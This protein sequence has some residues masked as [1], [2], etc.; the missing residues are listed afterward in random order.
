MAINNIATIKVGSS[1][2]K[3]NTVVAEVLEVEFIK[4]Q[5]GAI[6]DI[7]VAHGDTLLYLIEIT[8]NGSKP[9]HS[10]KFS[11]IVQPNATYIVGSFKV[12]G[13]TLVPAI[14]GS[15]LETTIALIA[16]G[17]TATVEFNVIVN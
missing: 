9:L 17:A 7:I 1:T 10:V 13:L 16:V 6:I 2:V 5:N 14:S 15:T 3:S 4:K 12:N 11:D 8:N